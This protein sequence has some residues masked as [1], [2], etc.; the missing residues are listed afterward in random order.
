MFSKSRRKQVDFNISVTEPL[1]TPEFVARHYHTPGSRSSSD[2]TKRLSR[3]F[4]PVNPNEMKRFFLAW[5]GVTI[6]QTLSEKSWKNPIK[7]KLQ[8]ASAI[9]CPVGIGDI[10]ATPSR[11]SAAHQI[12]QTVSEQLSRALV[13]PTPC[14]EFEICQTLSDRLAL[15][16]C[17][18]PS[19]K[20]QKIP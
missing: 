5:P 14:A 6:F 10:S 1:L 8:T 7:I 17:A 12:V 18:T 15:S 13:R 11:K 20:S 3:G 4:G 19:R 9:V 16:I 2:L